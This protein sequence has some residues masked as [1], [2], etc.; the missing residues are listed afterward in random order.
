MLLSR[1]SQVIPKRSLYCQ[2][3]KDPQEV[4]GSRQHLKCGAEWGREVRG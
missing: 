3:I 4:E 1:V 2:S